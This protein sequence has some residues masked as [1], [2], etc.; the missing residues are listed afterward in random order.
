[1]NWTRGSE[2]S[3]DIPKT[4]WEARRDR[5]KVRRSRARPDGFVGGSVDLV[6]RLDVSIGG[7]VGGS[8][9]TPLFLDAS[10]LTPTRLASQVVIP[11]PHADTRRRFWPLSFIL[12]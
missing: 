3:S 2:D 6:A 12:F 4:S 9:G 7:H 1:M 5:R 8:W 10:T 11:V